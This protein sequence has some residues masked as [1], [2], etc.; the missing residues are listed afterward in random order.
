MKKIFSVI[1]MLCMLFTVFSPVVPGGG[2]SNLLTDSE[3]QTSVGGRDMVECLALYGACLAGASE[4]P[5]G[6]I[7]WWGLLICSGLAAYCIS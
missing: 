1:L 3:L 5:G 7:T 2:T 6:G 4:V